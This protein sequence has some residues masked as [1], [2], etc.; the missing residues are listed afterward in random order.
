[1]LH[2]ADVLFAAWLPGS[3]GDGMADILFGDYPPAGK[4]THSW[5]RKMAQIP[6]NVNDTN[7]DPLYSYK[8]GITD[9]ADYSSEVAPIFHSALLQKNGKILELAFSKSMATPAESGGFTVKVNQT[10]RDIS[11]VSVKTSDPG[12]IEL[13]LAIEANAGDSLLVAYTA[14][15]VTASDGS[16]LESFEFQEVY[17]LRDEGSAEQAVPG[18]V[19]AENYSSMSGVQL[20]QTTD[21]GGGTNVG[22]IDQTD[23]M[24]YDLLVAD[25]GSYR[26]NLRVAALSQSARIGFVV[27]GKVLKILDLPITYGWQT[28]QTVATEIPLDQGIQKLKIFAFIGGFNLNWM[29]FSYL[30]AI[31]EN[32]SLPADFNFYPNYPNPFNPETV[33]VYDLPVRSEV[34]LAIFDSRGRKVDT[35]SR[36]WQNSGCHEVKWNGAGYSSG[37]YLARLQAGVYFSTRKIV[38][39]K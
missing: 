20:E 36:G 15:S 37:I 17:N 21:E 29:E 10:D 6:I 2:F 22:W 1:V 9:P 18:R 13:E 28:W 3:E 7:Y 32:S 38:L 26:V 5:P 24:E 19:E 8:H 27:G 39:I 4:L 30:T 34:T 11:T 31:E 14:G 16:L 25:S 12:I 23:W 33:L 35:L